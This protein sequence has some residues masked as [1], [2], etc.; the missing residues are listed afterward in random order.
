MKL[1][2]ILAKIIKLSKRSS[3]L[4]HEAFSSSTLRK[5]WARFPTN[6]LDKLIKVPGVDEVRLQGILDKIVQMREHTQKLDDECGANVGVK[7]KTEGAAGTKVIAELFFRPPQ[8]YDEC[9]ICIHLSATG[10]SSMNLFEN[11]LSN[12]ATGCPHFI[13]ATA[14]QRRNLA[15]KVKLCR[16]CFNPD[17]II[18][19]S[20]IKECS[21]AK[22]K[23]SYS[24]T[25]RNCKD[26][27][28]ICLLHKSENKKAMEKF[29]KDLQ[30]KGQNLTFTSSF[31]VQPSEDLSVHE[32][33]RKL[34]RKEK[35]KGI[36]VV[37]VP[38]GEPLFLF[39]AAQGK[40]KPVMTFYDTGCSH[41][42]FKEDIPGAQ[43]RGQLVT[44]GPFDIGGVGGLTTQ[45]LD[46]WVV[47]VPR[48]D[49]KRQYI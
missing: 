43:L 49:G 29:K 48:V 2:V 45:A 16:Q 40:T 31:T 12:Y 17:V 15:R 3:S 27:M 41:A 26:H 9:R 6:V 35:K 46:E 1:E 42:I 18:T 4:A 34:R 30:K 5:L 33:V 10:S 28:W 19:E 38:E 21:F 44:R 20:H 23:N 47:S 22:K 13:E 7:K 8:R 14:E 32:A 36:E 11:Y 25:N 24:C 37:P 39:H